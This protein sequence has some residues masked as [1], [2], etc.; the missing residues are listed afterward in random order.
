MCSLVVMSFNPYF[1]GLPILIN[2]TPN[3]TWVDFICFN[4]YFTGLPI[5]IIFNYGRMRFC[6]RFNPYFTG[7]PILIFF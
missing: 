7:L 6:V 2:E 3:G 4:P 1:T 5:L